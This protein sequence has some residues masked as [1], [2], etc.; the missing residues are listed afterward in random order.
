MQEDNPREGST[1]TFNRVGWS[2]VV[3]LHYEDRNSACFQHKLQRLLCG[4]AQKFWLRVCLIGRG[5]Y[6]RVPIG[7]LP[8]A[9][10]GV[11]TRRD[12]FQTGVFGSAQGRGTPDN[13]GAGGLYKTSFRWSVGRP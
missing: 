7:V 1:P 12:P 4:I 8:G 11:Q 9:L 2:Y 5:V 3:S 6:S 13:M 10:T